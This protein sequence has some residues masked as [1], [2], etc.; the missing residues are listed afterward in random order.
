MLNFIS[1]L[2]GIEVDF[3]IYMMSLTFFWF[4]A[5]SV[6]AKAILGVCVA[7]YR[8]IPLKGK[9]IRVG[10]P[11]GELLALLALGLIAIFVALLGSAADDDFTYMLGFLLLAV[12]TASAFIEFAVLLWYLVEI[13]ND[14]YETTFGSTKNKIK[15]KQAE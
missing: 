15:E 12:M 11:Y 6:L 3:K 2:L 14:W 5:L 13:I 8:M 9:T 4:L 1:E 10:T 7:A